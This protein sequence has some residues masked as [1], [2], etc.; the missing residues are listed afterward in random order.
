ME[1]R[2]RLARL[3]PPP[4]PLCCHQSPTS[5]RS[6]S[7]CR[8]KRVWTAPAAAG[9][10]RGKAA[11][12]TDTGSPG[13]PTAPPHP[14]ISAVASTACLS[15]RVLQRAKQQQKQQQMGWRRGAAATAQST[16][17]QRRALRVLAG[18]GGRCHPYATFARGQ[19]HG[20]MGAET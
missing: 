2:W 5:W 18:L 9:R 17:R 20:T 13:T 16:L 12:G 8:W 14:Q 7:A 3:H 6:L 19:S 10:G 1:R 11:A 4:P 15:A